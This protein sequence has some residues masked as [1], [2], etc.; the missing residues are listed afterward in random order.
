MRLLL[1]ALAL[2]LFVAPLHGAV[3]TLGQF[4]VSDSGAAVYTIPIQVPPG[5]AGMAPKLALVYNRQTGNGMLEVG[6]C[7]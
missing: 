6:C 7:L 5:S 1:R 2:L 4:S 3:Y